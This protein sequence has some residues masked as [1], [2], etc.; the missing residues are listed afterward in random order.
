VTH[1]KG[2]QAWITQF[3]LQTTPCLPLPRKHSPDGTTTVCGCKH[4]IAIYYSFVSP[5]R[6]SWPGVG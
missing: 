4:L 2:A 5:E 3:Y 1:P 6:L